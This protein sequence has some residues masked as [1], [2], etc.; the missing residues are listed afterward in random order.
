VQ[1]T[2]RADQPA[3]KQRVGPQ[4]D[5][6]A[7]S[8]QVGHHRVERLDLSQGFVIGGWPSVMHQTIAMTAL[9]QKC[10]SL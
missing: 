8:A 7:V 5:I 10:Q 6:A 2:I 9:A 1:P 3:A 4:A